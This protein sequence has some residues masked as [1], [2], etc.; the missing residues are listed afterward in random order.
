MFYKEPYYDIFSCCKSSYFRGGEMIFR[1]K[2]KNLLRKPVSVIFLLIL[3]VEFLYL[4]KFNLVH[5]YA[6]MDQDAA[7]LMT[8]AMEMVRTG[9]LLIPDWSYMTT[10]EIDSAMLLALPVY[11]VTGKLFFSFAVS[12]I[13]FMFVLLYVLMGIFKNCGI[14][15]EISLLICCLVYIPYNFGMLD[16]M[17]M[18]FI[19]GAQYSIKVLIPLLA[20]LIITFPNVNKKRDYALSAVWIFLSF[21]S[22][23]SSGLFPLI[24]GILPIAGAYYVNYAFRK[25][26]T[27]AITLFRTLLLASGFLASLIGFA[28]HQHYGISASGINATLTYSEEFGPRMFLNIGNFFNLLNALPSKYL[29][30]YPI[31]SFEGVGCI[32]RFALAIFLLISA[33]HFVIVFFGGKENHPSGDNAHVATGYMTAII[34][35]NVII[36]L[37]CSYDEARYYLVELICMMIL[38]G[39]WLSR[40]TTD[41]RKDTGI[42]VSVLLILF[43]SFTWYSSKK[44][45][46]TCQVTKDY[47]GFCYGICDFIREQNVDNVIIL[48]NSAVE[49]TCRV[50]LRDVKFS[51]YNSVDG[52]FLSEDWY[53]TTDERSYYGDTSIIVTQ[54]RDDL[55]PVFGSEVAS[56]YE[57]IGE[58]NGFNLFRADEFCLPLD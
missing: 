42:R 51:N 8:H 57:F 2:I 26:N 53:T 39:I 24:T 34:I 36:H 22:G 18:M 27:G 7:K 6:V 38:A 33:C 56:H 41:I 35:V 17:N 30:I 9:K 37:L 14:R 49:E 5:T 52:V 54:Y 19:R 3:F 29:N 4:I 40:L 15:S 31:V 44:F 46:D 25:K 43:T 28:L 58:V 23:F 45:V 32:F 12:N 50:I 11:A 55:E 13:I 21:L 20:I 48:D 1:D 16:Y 10:H 47:F